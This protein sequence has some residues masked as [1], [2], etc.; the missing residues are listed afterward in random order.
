MLVSRN[1]L[2]QL[3][4]PKF[5]SVRAFWWSKKRE[6][7]IL[8]D[9]SIQ[10]SSW[11]S[12]VL[13]VI[14]P[15]MHFLKHISVKLWMAIVTLVFLFGVDFLWRRIMI[16]KPSSQHTHLN[17]GLWVL[18]FNPLHDLLTGF[19]IQISQSLCIDFRHGYIGWYWGCQWNK[20]EKKSKNISTFLF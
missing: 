19:S 11:R 6:L 10:D 7:H 9:Y 20:K 1:L 13:E 15:V 2:R 12:K 14:F 5:M 3:E 4:R 16:N 18:R 8:H 17:L